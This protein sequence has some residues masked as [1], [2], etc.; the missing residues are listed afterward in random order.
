LLRRAYYI[1]PLNINTKAEYFVK[2]YN[3]YSHYNYLKPGIS[4]FLKTEHFEIA[5]QLTKKHFN[6]YNVIDFGCADGPFL[7][8]LSR[9]FNNVIGIDINS[10]L[11]QAANDLIKELKLKN[12]SLICNKNMKLIDLNSQIND[13]ADLLFLL[14]TLEHV[15]DKNRLYESKIDF[16][17]DLFT[18][19]NKDGSIIISVPKMIGFSF[20]LQRIGFAILRLYRT[21]ISM[22]NLIKA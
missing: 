7:P 22:Q 11:I 2:G 10:N 19:I 6:N 8:S 4:S 18:L 15:G 1:K 16:I 17:K 21:P 14:E 20:L 5:L 13:E 12:V 3:S 9:Y